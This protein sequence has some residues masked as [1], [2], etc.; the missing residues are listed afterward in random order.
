MSRYNPPPP[1]R[2]KR[3]FITTVERPI[4]ENE[5]QSWCILS[6]PD[7]RVACGPGPASQFARGIQY[8]FLGRWE[9]VPN[10]GFRFRFST[11]TVHQP[12]G[13]NGM[14]RYLCELCEGIGEKR[15][16][17]IWDVYGNAGL[18]ML[19]TGEPERIAEETKLPLDVVLDAGKSLREHHALESTRVDL[20]DLFAGRGFQGKLIG[21]A[22]SKWGAKAPA[23]I[24]RNPFAL[25]GMPSAGFVRCD[26]LW[27][28][29]GLP[30]DSLKR[31]TL[32]LWDICRSDRN[33]NTWIDALRAASD[34]RSRIPTADPVRAARLGIRARKLSVR[35]DADGKV[36]LADYR[37]A[38][39]EGRIAQ[40]LSRLMDGP[41]HWP[42]EIPTSRTDS[43]GLPSV[44]QVEQL[45]LATAGP[46]GILCG[47]PGT[48]KSHAIGYLLR[49]IADGLCMAEIAICA[50]TGKAANR[51]TEAMRAAGLGLTA[52]T[53]HTLLEI[54]RNGHDGDGW[55]FKRNARN[56]LTYRV[57]I[58]DE[59]SMIDVNLLA[60]LLDACADGTHVLF[61]GD[62]YQL[63]PVGHG[64]PLRDLIAT[65]IPYGE[66]TQVRRNSGQIVHACAR[67]RNGEQFEFSNSL[68]L[69]AM[70][71]QNLKVVECGSEFEVVQ[72]LESLL[73]AV[74]SFHPVWQTQVIVARNKGTD[75][76]RKELNTRLHNLLNPDGVTAR[77]CPWSV[78]DKVICLR[79][80]FLEVVDS[81]DGDGEL[82]TNADEYMPR[83]LNHDWDG[84]YET[85]KRKEA[86][87]VYTANGEIGRVVAVG[88]GKA[89][90]RFS[91]RDDLVIVRTK[92]QRQ[93]DDDN[94][95]SGDENKDLFDLAYAVTGHKMQGS[96]APLTIVVLTESSL[97]VANREWLYTAI[98]R[99]SKACVILCT[100]G[101]I[102]KS[103]GRVALAR[104]KTFLSETLTE[105]LATASLRSLI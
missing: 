6:L 94:D 66:L 47:S 76:G 95:S 16:T 48:G 71:P 35:R 78:G 20:Y 90:C 69:A 28:D 10:R 2:T 18:E 40:S 17:R 65:E 3:E 81:V 19:R 79:N 23:V 50:P 92:V 25:L 34:L 83:P 8:R 102:A 45:L 61:V 14:V 57:V 60:D 63:P 29:L 44:H 62:P 13:R 98:S 42:T 27:K 12:A 82:S 32:C 38:S 1:D 21:R 64:A 97:S 86:E 74:K 85:P 33:G 89:I 24:R 103:V 73:A 7:N 53:I 56:P 87:Q 88:A 72:S 4:F 5:D 39:S 51:A 58:I 75:T 96:Q 31:Q 105:L 15:A 100:R 77:D 46:V 104:R 91:E 55:G 54:G 9:D 22:V 26:R 99:A 67:I 101:V 68:D 80:T 84:E 70:P 93:D 30:L 37:M 41:S 59:S 36:W 49:T 52:T 43:D 11:H